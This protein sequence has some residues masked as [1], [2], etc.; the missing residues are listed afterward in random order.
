MTSYDVASF[1]FR[2][3]NCPHCNKEYV[4]T[5]DGSGNN[6]GQEDLILWS[7]E[8]GT[9]FTEVDE[10]QRI[11]FPPICKCK[12][13]NGI[14]WSEESVNTHCKKMEN[15]EAAWKV[16]NNS[17]RPDHLVKGDFIALYNNEALS[18]DQRMLALEQFW[19]TYCY[20]YIAEHSYSN[21]FYNG[22]EVIKWLKEPYFDVFKKSLLELSLNSTSD[23][24]FKA[25]LLRNLG[26]YD[27]A[28]QQLSKAPNG[29][30]NY[31]TRYMI[32]ICNKKIP[33]PVII[34]PRKPASYQFKKW[35]NRRKPGTFRLKPITI[36]DYY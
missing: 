1:L 15:A 28:T 5:T 13:C 16:L 10:C 22:K 12:G 25:E 32:S 27:E 31:V 4:F 23:L 8:V 30:W 34:P 6:P 18:N 21:D 17:L 11:P 29:K 3:L 9:Y 26:M 36:E 2:F 33:T 35:L 20:D 19:I 14:I 7:T 24:L